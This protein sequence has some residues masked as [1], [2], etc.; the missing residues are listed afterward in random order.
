MPTIY[1]QKLQGRLSEDLAIE[2]IEGNVTFDKEGLVLDNFVMKTTSSDFSKSDIRIAFNFL[3]TTANLENMGLDIDI[4]EGSLDPKDLLYFSPTL[5]PFFAQAKENLN[6][7][8]TKITG[9]LKL[10]RNN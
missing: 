5:E 6:V 7:K 3:D 4:P 8:D 9:S 1:I 10:T 2:N